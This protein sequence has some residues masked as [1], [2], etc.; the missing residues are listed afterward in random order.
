L[1]IR[2]FSEEYTEL[3]IELWTE[4]GLIKPWN[5]PYKDI[6]RK[7][8]EDPSMFFIGL[9]EKELIASCMV[10]YDGHRGWMYYLAVKKKHRNKGYAKQ[11][12][13]YAEQVLKD[14]G[15][16]KVE[17]MVRED[18]TDVIDFYSIVGYN[19]ETVKVMSKRLIP[20]N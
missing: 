17:L 13:N 14:Q 8:D 6:L 1:K 11:L 5:D 15:C 10:G 9:N 19:V 4:A 18:N 20:D 12:V 16:P 2:S 3:L 7:M